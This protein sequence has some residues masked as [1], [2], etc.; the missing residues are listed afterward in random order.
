MRKPETAALESD[1]VPRFLFKKTLAMRSIA[2][3]VRAASP[4]AVRRK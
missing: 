4:N 3:T 2:S 1:T